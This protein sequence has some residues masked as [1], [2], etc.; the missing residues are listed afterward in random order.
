LAFAF[1]GPSHWTD[2]KGL[3]FGAFVSHFPFAA[4][5]LLAAAHGPA[6]LLASSRSLLAGGM[7][8]K[9]RQ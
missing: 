8:A 5:M 4:A 1:H 6:R 2:E 7:V 9:E 3:E